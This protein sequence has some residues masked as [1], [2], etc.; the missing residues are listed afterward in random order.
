MEQ[1]KLFQYLYNFFPSIYYFCLKCRKNVIDS[2]YPY[3]ASYLVRFA[4]HGGTQ[5]LFRCE[6]DRYRFFAQLF[7]LP[8][9]FS[10]LHMEIKS[11]FGVWLTECAIFCQPYRSWLKQHMSGFI[12]KFSVS[13]VESS[14]TSNK[15][16]DSRLDHIEKINNLILFHCI[17]SIQI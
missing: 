8:F 4:A 6:Q 2:F 7:S 11:L 14:Y 12:A 9:F 13:S 16:K 1:Y 5:S 17:S 15:K 3:S 10:S